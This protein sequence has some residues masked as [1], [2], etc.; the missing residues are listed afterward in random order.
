VL[1][2]GGREI[3]HLA[4]HAAGHDAAATRADVLRAQL[5]EYGLPRLVL[6][7]HG[8]RGGMAATAGSG[9]RGT[10]SVWVNESASGSRARGLTMLRDALI[11]GPLGN[12][13]HR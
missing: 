3:T 4:L 2:A 1:G 7:S 13:K 12:S 9:R 11:A 10:C 8:P 5:G 6:Q